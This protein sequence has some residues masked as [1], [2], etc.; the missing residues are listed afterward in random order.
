[1]L[2][3]L[4][5]VDTDHEVVARALPVARDAV[6]RAEP[7]LAL[8]VGEVEGDTV[9]ERGPPITVNVTVAASSYTASPDWATESVHAPPAFV[10]VTAPVLKV[11]ASEPEA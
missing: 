9:T 3:A 5:V 4:E 10:K 8:P 6:A 7:D 1:V 11:P 2:W